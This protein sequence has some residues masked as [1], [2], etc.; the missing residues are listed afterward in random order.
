MTKID[1]PARG[2]AVQ[3]AGATGPPGSLGHGW[4]RPAMVAAHTGGSSRSGRRSSPRSRSATAD[5][6]ATVRSC[7]KSV[8]EIEFRAVARRHTRPF[9]PVPAAGVSNAVAAQAAL[10]HATAASSIPSRYSG[11]PDAAGPF[12][13]LVCTSGRDAGLHLERPNPREAPVPPRGPAGMPIGDRSHR[14]HVPDRPAL[15]LT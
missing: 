1:S 5:W 8:P 4:L 3:R 6:V 11:P 9:S 13:G 7:V 12:S 2:M 15:P 14:R 10:P